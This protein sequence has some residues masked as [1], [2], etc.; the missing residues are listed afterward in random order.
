MD[1]LRLADRIA[2]G[3]GQAARKAGV[4]CDAYRPKNGG[5][6][7]TD[8]NRTLR[9]PVVF[10]PASG[11]AKAP[12]PFGVPYRQAVLDQAYVRAGDYLAGPV[13]TY[14]VATN[15]P[16]QPV[17]AMLCNEVVSIWRAASPRLAGVN[18]YGAIL[19][20]T[21]VA[22]LAG[23]PAALL[24]GGT[25]DR[26]RQ[27]LPDDTKV[28]GFVAMLAAVDGI[29]PDVADIVR[30]ARGRQFVITSAERFGGCWRLSMT[31]SVT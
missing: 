7:M 30:D 17:L 13:G 19:S 16:P 27:G 20:A 22:L 15:E 25:G 4:I 28:S 12:A 23:F 3:A 18:P 10:M 31:E 11:T 29:M 6:P 26:T 24:P 5:S 8:A 21:A 14:V 9:M 2:Y 1:G